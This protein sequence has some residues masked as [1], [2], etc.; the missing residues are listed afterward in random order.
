[1]EKA[2]KQQI[3]VPVDFSEVSSNALKYAV[4]VARIFKCQI[5]LLHV[6]NNKVKSSVEKEE[7]AKEKLIPIAKKIIDCYNIPANIYVLKGN[8]ISIINS[9][10][11]GINAIMI[12]VGLD[13]GKGKKNKYFSAKII[14]TRFKTLR[15]PILVV[16]KKPPSHIP[17]KN[18][19]LPVDFRKQAK[20]KAPWSSYFS[21]LNNSKIHVVFKEYKDEY[22]IKQLH[23]N[24]KLIK[25]SFDTMSVHFS[26]HKVENINCSID[27]YAIA[28]AK[29]NLSDMV[30]ILNTDDF[31]IDD[32][33]FGPA[34]QRLIANE[35]Q[36]P[37]MC[38]NP[39]D[40]LFIPCV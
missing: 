13:T 7:Q 6:I 5:S 28:Y 22:F 9:I 40:D 8:Y 23:N 32:Q 37:V 14:S 29:V 34:E 1:L 35:E 11:E 30:I 16:Q 2:K 10:I 18:I 15:I 17:F 39:R 4:E 24:I 12:V 27:K 19:I 3:L 20:E 36:I 25:R 31:A 38:L 26:I 33:L 21:K